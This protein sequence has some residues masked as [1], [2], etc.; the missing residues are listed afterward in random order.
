MQ[1]VS[2]SDSF[3]NKISKLFEL[4]IHKNLY[5]YLDADGALKMLKYHNLQFTNATKLNDP[6]DCHPSLIDFSNVPAEKCRIWSANDIS[7]LESSPY[8]RNHQMAWICSL[9]KVYDSLLMWSYYGAH[10][11]VCIGIDMT[12][13]RNY[14]HIPNG[15]YLDAMEMEVQYKDVV[16]KPDFFFMPG[17]IDYFSYQLSTKAKAWEHEKEVRLVLIN[18]AVGLIPSDYPKDA[19]NDDGSVDYK[20]VRFYPQI[21]KECFN[22]LYLGGN[23]DKKK[24]KSLIETARKCNPEMNIYRMTIDPNAFRLVPERIT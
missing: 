10:K 7:A 9:S 20:E 5:K 6:F 1:E 16:E 18:P 23:V 24:E 22:A 12:K 8:K 3:F 13:A 19:C 15:V 4:Q 2:C 11:G 14:L 21:G 17:M